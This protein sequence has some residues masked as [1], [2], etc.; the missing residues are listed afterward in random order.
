MGGEGYVVVRKYVET[1]QSLPE[2]QSDICWAEDRKDSCKLS[3]SLGVPE[4]PSD[5]DVCAFKV[6]LLADVE[7]PHI[8]LC[9]VMCGCKN[10]RDIKKKAATTTTTTTTTLYVR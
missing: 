9:N 10:I 4:I 6:M 2:S 5:T 7:Q 8:L 3:H 1:N